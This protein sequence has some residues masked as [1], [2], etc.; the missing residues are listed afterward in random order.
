[1][2]NAQYQ[3][4][5]DE[6]S[7]TYKDLDQV[8]CHVYPS[9]SDAEQAHEQKAVVVRPFAFTT[10]DGEVNFADPVSPWFLGGRQI[11]KFGCV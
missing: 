6:A 11:E 2:L 4:Q 5:P 8:S 7:T 1:M 3:K 9:R 10:G